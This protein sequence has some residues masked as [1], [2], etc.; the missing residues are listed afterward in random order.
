MSGRASAEAQ[1]SI[2]S[3]RPALQHMWSTEKKH[4]QVAEQLL[5]QHR[6]RPSALIPLWSIAG[7]VLGGATALMGPRAA[8]ACT[9]AVETVIG[10][11]YDE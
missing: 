5:S 10:E 7:R 8:M 3:L 6:V 4:L 11:H 9:E 2:S 1:G